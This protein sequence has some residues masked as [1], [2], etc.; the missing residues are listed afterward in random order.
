ME[1]RRRRSCQAVC[2]SRSPPFEAAA[3]CAT[4]RDFCNRSHKPGPRRPSFVR[5]SPQVPQDKALDRGITTHSRVFPATSSRL[6][7]TMPCRPQI[8]ASA[9]AQQRPAAALS[10]YARGRTPACWTSH[11]C[12]TRG[13]SAAESGTSWCFCWRSCSRWIHG[14]A[15]RSPEQSAA[16]A[17]GTDSDGWYRKDQKYAAAPSA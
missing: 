5:Q 15:V 3:A 6:P 2:R 17:L 14:G 8:F 10:L 1:K 4:R 16:P 7:Q 12:E 11:S 9:P 13:A